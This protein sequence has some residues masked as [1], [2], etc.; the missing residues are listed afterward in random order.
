MPVKLI[1]LWE[2]ALV[3]KIIYAKF[4]LLLNNLITFVY[5]KNNFLHRSETFLINHLDY[6]KYLN[7]KIETFVIVS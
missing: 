5:L 7:K 1:C 3:F 4:Y 2:R 6:L